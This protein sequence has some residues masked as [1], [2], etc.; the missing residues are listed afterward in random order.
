MP[1]AVLFSGYNQRAVLALLRTCAQEGVKVSLVALA[2]DDPITTTA[3]APLVDVV[4]ADPALT[5]QACADIFGAL[6][7]RY[8]GERLVVLP[9]TEALNRF[10]LR[11]RPWFDERGI[12]V[13]LCGE[14]VYELVSDKKS[15]GAL[16]G[17]HGIAIPGEFDLPPPAPFV[18]KPAVYLSARGRAL[19][20]Q[21]VL[22]E[23]QRQRFLAEAD[24]ADFYFQQYLSG[25][26]YYLLMYLPR[27][28]A[29]PLVFGQRN[30]A[31]QPEGKSIVAART[32]EDEHLGATG[33]AFARLFRSAGFSGLAMVEV[34]RHGGRDYMIECNP[35]AWGPLQ[36]CVDAGYS[37]LPAFLHD[38]G[39]LEQV[40]PAVPRAADYLWSGGIGPHGF[41][42]LSY[43]DGYGAPDLARDYFGLCTSDVYLRPD[44]MNI[45]YMEAHSA[46]R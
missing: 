4:R 27:N 2:A 35:R 43:F 1:R 40:R 46:A 24:P 28:G 19:A 17:R 22:T 3:Y 7:R 18:A 32:V 38:W 36:L 37:L 29:A 8:P 45:Y 30:L 13:P 11:H 33:D 23:A 25:E 39:L 42:G 5:L 20:P 26:S 44:S 12:T 31:Q 34:R 6:Q 21:L 16:C 10:L 14:P 15:F 9:S 41:A